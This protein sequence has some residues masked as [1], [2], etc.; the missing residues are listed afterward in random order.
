ME[1]RGGRNIKIMANRM[2]FSNILLFPRS[3]FIAVMLISCAKT[4]VN[5]NPFSHHTNVAV[6]FVQV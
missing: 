1:Q 4:S 5:D 3:K 2:C 6:A